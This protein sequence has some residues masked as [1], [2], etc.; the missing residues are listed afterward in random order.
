MLSGYAQG[1]YLNFQ[2]NGPQYPPG[3]KLRGPPS[4]VAKRKICGFARYQ[5]SI[6]HLSSYYTQTQWLLHASH[7]NRIT[8]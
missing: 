3:K 8:N 6:L 7:A 4:M 2:E 5:T 1:L